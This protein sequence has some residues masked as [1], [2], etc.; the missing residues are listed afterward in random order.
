MTAPWPP[1]A[2]PPPR[3]KRKYEPEGI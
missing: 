3:D 1:A 2:A